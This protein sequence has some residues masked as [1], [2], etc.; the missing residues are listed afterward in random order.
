MGKTT[1]ASP[2]DV[3]NGGDR[4][5]TAR[6]Q[7][8]LERGCPDWIAQG[9]SLR[10]AIVISLTFAQPSWATGSHNGINLGSQATT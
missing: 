9:V 5:L 4:R 10:R 8:F 2:S 3:F 7:W 6:L 1:A